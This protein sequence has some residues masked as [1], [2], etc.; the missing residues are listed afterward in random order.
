MMFLSGLLISAVTLFLPIADYYLVRGLPSRVG[1]WLILLRE[2]LRD[3]LKSRPA[4]LDIVRGC[5]MGAC[6]LGV[7]TAMLGALGAGRLAGPGLLWLIGV[8]R[9]DDSL[10]LYAV[11]WVIVTTIGAAWLMVGWPAALASRAS[12]RGWVLLTV[13]T[14]LWLL[15]AFSLQGASAF[16]LFPAILFAGLQGL[17]FSWILYQYDFLTLL[18]TMFTVETWLIAYPAFLILQKAELLSS[19]L[20]LLPWFLLFFLGLTLYL[21]PRLLAAWRRMAA[22]FE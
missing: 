5:A 10:I 18:A 3:K 6:Y 21:H 4:G 22:V 17:F 12:Q 20:A 9:L 19:L 2:K 13:P 11:S 8:G 1:L 14:C 7:H 15:S 16:P